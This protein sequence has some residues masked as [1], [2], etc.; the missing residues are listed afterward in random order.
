MR[1]LGD[2]AARWYAARVLGQIGGGRAIAALSIALMDH[3]EDVVV[4]ATE[5]LG[6]IGDDSA[7]R[8]LRT[9]AGSPH[10]E[11]LRD[12]ARSA[13]EQIERRR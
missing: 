1:N 4:E 3:D 13:A 8:V 2:P 11:I 5:G 10:D 9:F 7:A 6:R 12:R